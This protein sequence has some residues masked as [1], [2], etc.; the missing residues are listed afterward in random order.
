[1]FYC[2]WSHFELTF[3]L[4]SFLFY[5]TKAKKKKKR[6][7]RPGVHLIG[8][9]LL[10]VLEM[11]GAGPGLFILYT[12]NIETQSIDAIC[13]KFNLCQSIHCWNSTLFC[14]FFWGFKFVLLF[15]AA[16]I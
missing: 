6:R 8:V 4:F 16:R 12:D 14:V 5:L 11:T 3:F 13:Q 7:K 1:M 10:E 15:Q 2:N 9:I